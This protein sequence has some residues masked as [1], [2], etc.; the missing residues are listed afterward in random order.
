MIFNMAG[1]GASLNFAV[2]GGTSAPSNPKENTI[3]VNTATEITGWEFSATQPAAAAGL[4][5][6]ATGTSS[7]TAFEALKKNGIEVYPIYAKQYVNGAWVT[8]T[9]KIYQGGNWVA[10]WDNYLYKH[11]DPYAS[12][13]GGW[14]V[15]VSKYDG[16]TLTTDNGSGQMVMSR[17]A[18]TEGVVA[19]KNKI[20]LSGFTKMSVMMYTTGNAEFRV[21][22]T[23]SPTDLAYHIA[24]KIFTSQVYQQL[25]EIDIS[26]VDSGYISFQTYSTSVACQLVV[27]YIYLS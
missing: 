25:V 14:Y 19:T 21:G 20:D 15:S 24:G 2:V 8:K 23:S 12:V 1:G 22:I 7:K 5:W 18:A 4:V 27:D 13:T 10:F 17:G 16:A 9:A 11:G 26:S 6:F 3:W